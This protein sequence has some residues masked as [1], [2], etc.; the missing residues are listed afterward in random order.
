MPNPDSQTP[1]PRPP[2]GHCP[3]R[4]VTL[5][6]GDA[7]DILRTLPAAE[8]DCVVT[9]PPYWRLRD[10]ATGTWTG[11]NPACTHQ[12]PA[13]G[14]QD[15]QRRCHRCGALW[16]DN[17]Y[18]LETTP[19]DYVDHLRQVFAELHRVLAPTGTVWLNLGDSYSANSDGYHNTR[20]GQ[21]RQPRYR[22]RTG[23]PHKNLIGMPWRTALALQT[24]GWTVK[25]AVV[26]HKT[27]AAPFPVRDRLSNQYETVFLLV[28]QHHSVHRY[29]THPCNRGA[30]TPSSTDPARPPRR[31]DLPSR[32]DIADTGD[33][34][35]IPV[36][37]RRDQQHPATFP[38][39]I[40][41]RCIRFGSPPSGLVCDPF[42]GT[43]TTGLAARQL[44]RVYLGIDLNPAFTQI[45]ADRLT[46]ESR[47]RP[48]AGDPARQEAR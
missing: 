45:A 26:W 23:L 7:A 30:T 40:P 5:L 27:N 11:G 35:S 37:P 34:W 38:L 1:L 18:G 6:S 43:G 8:V 17:Q 33:V 20:P 46:A 42:S 48:S 4:S 25:N 13:D 39:D 21:Y 3:Q 24:D 19:G 47:P 9:S 28:K 16:L 44:G 41:L 2:R 10:Y 15:E 29:T 12:A 22:P 31:R 36:T 14:S 32:R